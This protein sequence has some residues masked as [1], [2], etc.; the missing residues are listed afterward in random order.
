MSR[1]E[2]IA[3]LFEKID[4][5]TEIL[6]KVSESVATLNERSKNYDERLRNVEKFV[7]R[8][9]TLEKKSDV[10]DCAC[11]NNKEKIDKITAIEK[12]I[13]KI[14]RDNWGISG[15]M[16]FLGWILGLAIG[17]IISLIGLFKQ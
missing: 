4:K 10:M 8:I 16:S 13:G 5:Q 2:T 9:E 17:L 14:K 15:I 11:S 12:D 3:R 1:E 7:G 6:N